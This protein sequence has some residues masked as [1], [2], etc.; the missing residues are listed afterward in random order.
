[1]V[2]IFWDRHYSPTEVFAS[3]FGADITRKDLL[4]LSGTEWLNDEGEYSYSS[5]KRSEMTC[6]LSFQLSTFSSILLLSETSRN[7]TFRRWLSIEKRVI[8]L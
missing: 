8:I 1:M 4:T 3:G 7:P 5:N 2:K 6:H